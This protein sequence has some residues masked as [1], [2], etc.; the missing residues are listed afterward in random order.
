MNS[1]SAILFGLQ[2]V[3]NQVKKGLV[4][5]IYI[6]CV[7][8]VFITA[9]PK[10]GSHAWVAQV[11]SDGRNVDFFS[12]VRRKSSPRDQAIKYVD[13]K[14]VRVSGRL[15]VATGGAILLGRVPVFCTG[16]ALATQV[17]KLDPLLRLG[18]VSEYMRSY[19]FGQVGFRGQRSKL[20]S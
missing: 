5:L 14:C 20:L 17:S 4:H 11:A 1:I 7:D 18:F 6:M 3:F 16:P 8:K 19:F 2:A 13:G 10:D 15:F 12:F 9:Y